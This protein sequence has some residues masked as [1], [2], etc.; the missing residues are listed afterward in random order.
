MMETVFLFLSNSNWQELIAKVPLAC[1]R[2]NQPE[3]L[4]PI[5]K[6]ET[7]NQ[8][9]DILTNSPIEHMSN[10][11]GIYTTLSS[12]RLW[13]LSTKFLG[14]IK[15]WPA[16]T[17]LSLNPSQNYPWSITLS[18]YALRKARNSYIGSPRI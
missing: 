2:S 1:L 18:S 8:R 4:Q 16:T 14:I 17:W 11:R 15:N 9:Q 3:H 10:G 6:L 12:T 13:V 7:S 5:T